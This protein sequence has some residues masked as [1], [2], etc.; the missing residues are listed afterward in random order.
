LAIRT[1]VLAIHVANFS[2][3][4]FAVAPPLPAEKKTNLQKSCLQEKV[5]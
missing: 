5:V 1:G 2:D 3:C 4:I